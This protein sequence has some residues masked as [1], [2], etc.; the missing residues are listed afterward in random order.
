MILNSNIN[1]VDQT[2]SYFHTNDK[3]QCK[4][5]QYNNQLLKKQQQMLNKKQDS[6]Q[7]KF[8]VNYK[9]RAFVL[10]LFIV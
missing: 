7:F 9:N 8:S 1:L 6:I 3:Q 4:R 2:K 10:R 5:M